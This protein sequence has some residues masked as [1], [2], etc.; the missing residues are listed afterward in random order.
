MKELS[1]NLTKSQTGDSVAFEACFDVF[2]ALTNDKN[3]R[4]ILRSSKDNF[5][6]FTQVVKI[7]IDLTLK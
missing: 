5:E 4:D 3:M 7:C 1:E 2:D 6:H